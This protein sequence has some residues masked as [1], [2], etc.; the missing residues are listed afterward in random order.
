MSNL[1]SQILTA[2]DEFIKE[3]YLYT[4][5]I[6]AWFKARQQRGFKNIGTTDSSGVS[7]HNVKDHAV[8]L[9]K[10]ENDPRGKLRIYSYPKE[11]F[12]ANMPFIIDDE[13]EY[14]Q[15]SL[16]HDLMDFSLDFFKKVQEFYYTTEWGIV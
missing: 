12:I 15:L 10:D 5:D 9:V 3:H 4:N 2:M 7:L 11:C 8:Y 14:F 16:V 1:E 6:Q 13:A